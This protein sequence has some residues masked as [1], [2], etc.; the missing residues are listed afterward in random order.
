MKKTR[1][2]SVVIS[3]IMAFAVGA[4]FTGCSEARF[5]GVVIWGAQE[6]QELIEELIREF[7]TA[8][9]DV[10]D[11]IKY[12]HQ[13]ISDAQSV[14]AK[15]PAAAADVIMIPHDQIGIMAKSGLLGEIQDSTSATFKTDIIN[16]NHESA[17][18][19]VTY[20]EKI[21][22]FPLT[23]DTY[24]LYYN[25]KIFRD[26]SEVAKETLKSVDKML[27]T[28][29]NNIP[30]TNEKQKAFGF[31]IGDGFYFN[32]G[33]FANGGTLYGE[34][35]D[36]VNACDWDNAAGLEVMNY[37]IENFTEAG[38]K[39]KSDSAKNLATAVLN[40]R[41]GACISGGWEMQ[42]TFKDATDIGYTT[43]PSINLGGEAKDLISFSNS[44]V[45]TINN[46]STKKGTAIR[47]ANYV[48]SQAAQ[49][50]WAEKRSYYPSNK[51][52]QNAT[53]IT[54]NSLFSVIKAQLDKS[55]PIPIIP[56]ITRYWEP[57]KALGESV[58]NGSLTKAKAAGELTKFVE[59]LK[60]AL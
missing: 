18:K 5:D 2:I 16:N 30:G 47:L 12:E 17:V 11:E 59:S 15:D 46:M 35:G 7:K 27:A 20:N 44:K 57:A 36:D 28:A 56:E 54:S 40:Q 9:P 23:M 55:V 4:A 21:Y 1:L 10:T 6:D 32:M 48:T 34:D 13:G 31:N 50:K 14:V 41:L 45:Y 43:L 8:N 39:F 33:F 49:M 38:G 37:Y 58:Y 29:M 25:T 24:F 42:D 22:G 51:A 3:C 19:Q 60:S 53:E 52:A 26:S